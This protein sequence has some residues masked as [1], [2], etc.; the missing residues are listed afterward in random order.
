MLNNSFSG[1]VEVKLVLAL[2]LQ[3][4]GVFHDVASYVAGIM[5]ISKLFNDNFC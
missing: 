2:I 1:F 5:A 4:Y 3:T